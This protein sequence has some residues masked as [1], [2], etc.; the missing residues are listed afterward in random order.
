MTADTE[1]LVAALVR[2]ELPWGI[3]TR[4]VHVPPVGQVEV[5][6]PMTVGTPPLRVAFREDAKQRREGILNRREI[7]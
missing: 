2:L 4:V 1:Q 3:W 7:P 5:E 6:L